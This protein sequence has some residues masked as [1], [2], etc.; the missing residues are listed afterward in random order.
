M[1][2]LRRRACWLKVKKNHSLW[3]PNNAHHS[4]TFI[5]ISFHLKKKE[6]KIVVHFRD[7]IIVVVSKFQKENK[8]KGS[9]FQLKAKMDYLTFNCSPFSIV[10]HFEV[11]TSPDLSITVFQNVGHL[12]RTRFQPLIVVNKGVQF[13]GTGEV[14]SITTSRLPPIP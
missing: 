12:S 1:A 11:D 13:L 2:R 5:F 6:R 4:A 8:K 3:S 10:G 14:D 7:S 9:V